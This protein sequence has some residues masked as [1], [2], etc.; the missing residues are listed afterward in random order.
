M[1]TTAF[2]VLIEIVCMNKRAYRPDFANRSSI[3][4]ISYINEETSGMEW[5]TL[6][7]YL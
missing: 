7:V 3:V 1:I 4:H 2:N 6:A 5:L